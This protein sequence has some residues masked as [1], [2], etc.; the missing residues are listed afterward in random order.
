MVELLTNDPKKKFVTAK[1]A[2]LK[3]GY[4][5]DYVGRLA[6]E[7][8]VDSY[9][10]GRQ[11]FVELDS[12]KLFTLGV[13]A[14]ARRRQEKVKQER[15]AELVQAAF[16]ELE[17]KAKLATD[18]SY[19]LSLIESAVFMLLGTVATV[20]GG[21]VYQEGVTT[22]DLYTGMTDVQGEFQA[23][24]LPKAWPE[25]QGWWWLWR[26]E[27]VSEV[28]QVDDS[29]LVE[30][31]SENRQS[32]Q[33]PQVVKETGT[34][35]VSNQDQSE[36]ESAVISVFSDQVDVA[37]VRPQAGYVSPRFGAAATNTYPFVIVDQPVI[38]QTVHE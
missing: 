6:R 29:S 4:T 28:V 30:V 37:F 19:K 23:A 35:M 12:L 11:W 25:W 27:R 3:V 21:A 36:A 20:L 26:V 9:K 17:P 8:K 31:G 15:R 5:A 10:D 22:A 38:E 13:E 33:V 34:L 32:Y 7:G 1:E 2:A 14:E 18:Q 16:A 24:L